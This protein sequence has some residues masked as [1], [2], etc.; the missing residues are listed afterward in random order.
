MFRVV[1]ARKASAQELMAFHSTEYVEC[2]E[3]LSTCDDYQ[4]IEDDLAEFGLGMLL[5]CRFDITGC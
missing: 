2:L 4:E 5:R 1:P 3:K